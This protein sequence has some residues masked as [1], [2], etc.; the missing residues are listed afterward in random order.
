M[1]SKPFDYRKYEYKRDKILK[2]PRNHMEKLMDK[3]RN[4]H[5][6]GTMFFLTGGLILLH[7]WFMFVADI[8]VIYN[9]L[10]FTWLVFFSRKYVLPYKMPKSAD[11]MDPHYHY[12]GTTK[13][14]P[15]DGILY[16]GNE[17]KTNEEIWFTN[18]DARTHILYLGTTGS[19]KTEGLKT[20]AS[21]ALGWGSGFIYVDGKAD[22][23]LWGSLSALAR[24]FGRDD[25]LLVLNYMTGNSDA[26]I[27]S[28]T[29]NPFAQ[30][31]ASYL[32]NLLVSLM[33]E[34]QGENAMWK[35][36]AVAL[37]SAL[38]PVLTWQ[39]TYQEK[40]LNINTIRD[41][42]IFKKIIE[43][44]RL[45][46]V[47][48][49][50]RKGVR[51]YLDT[52]PGYTDN[53]FNDDGTE[54]PAQ[55]G[56]PMDYATIYQ[57]HGYLA[58][59]FTR[60]LQ[61]LADD[62]GYIFETPSADIDMMDV[63][64]NRRIVIV[65]I[66]ALEKSADETA[67]L[68]KIV[69]S[70]LKGMMGATLGS[71][72]EGD[73]EIA[74]ENKPTRASTPFMAIFDE[75]GYY[76]TQGMAVMAAQAR[77]LGFCMVFAAQDMPAL[78][79]RVKEEARSIT[80]NCNLKIF[81]K[82]E[83]PTQTKEF[84]E[85]TVGETTVIESSTRKEVK[86]F[87]GQKRFDHNDS[88][89]VTSR[90]KASYD[91]LKGFKD[92]QSIIAFGDR[93]V[94]AQWMLSNPGKIKSLR[95]NKFITLEPADPTNKRGSVEVDA[96]MER[97]RDKKWT[98]ENAIRKSEPDPVIDLLT[99]QYKKAR[100]QKRRF[101]EAAAYALTTTAFEKGI[102]TEKDLQAKPAP[103]P[104]AAPKPPSAAAQE[105]S[106]PAKQIEKPKDDFAFQTLPK[107][108]PEP[109]GKPDEAAVAGTAETISWGALMGEESSSASARQTKDQT[110]SSETSDSLPSV[111]ESVSW[112]DLMSGDDKSSQ[113][114]PKETLEELPKS[115]GSFGLGGGFGSFG[116]GFGGIGGLTFPTSRH[117]G[118]ATPAK[119]E[120][121]KDDSNNPQDIDS[122]LEKASEEGETVNWKDLF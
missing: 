77:S 60:Q 79:K 35:D 82:L 75:V 116:S 19:G 110:P 50:L 3:L 28:N 115:G 104:A 22:T 117:G 36:R 9:A 100:Y 62:Y 11:R 90:A 122:K 83:D 53:G 111:E 88:F 65:L 51:G 34:I 114:L 45:P 21:N 96:I 105:L 61:S 106:A 6:G 71:T 14:R 12:P 64:L 94:Q 63:V 46:E 73:T 15:A 29:I 108:K 99:Q 48:E 95:V 16:I 86:A 54:K 69:G 38:M 44:S 27:A 10:F 119:P 68:G 109:L 58:M 80:A 103:S 81:G 5:T 76:A 52:L 8:F 43:L 112:K 85:K 41:S 13:P 40:V 18:S 91:Q 20:L 42:L 67:N 37:I 31:S 24:R 49:R 26:K 92:G 4:P 70:M 47:P 56:P 39:R 17:A 2:D 66:P 72:V 118:F 102:L 120:E 97:I 87:F 113:G 84:F 89:N 74:L 33:P 57:Q 78:E 55:G 1:S 107:E 101:S 32:T 93:V 23:D 98:A 25:D 30:G 121:S 59:Q 7:P